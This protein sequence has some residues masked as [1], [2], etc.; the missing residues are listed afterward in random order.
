MHRAIIV[1]RSNSSREITDDLVKKTR[2]GAIF[3]CN[4]RRPISFALL[5][6][7]KR[8]Q[9]EKLMPGEPVKMAS[10]PNATLRKNCA[11]TAIEHPTTYCDKKLKLY[12]H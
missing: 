12:S 4:K 7:P 10:L 9:R 11:K 3:S 8:T 5:T 2:F 1:Q 6:T